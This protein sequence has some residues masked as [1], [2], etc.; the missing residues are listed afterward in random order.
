MPSNLPNTDVHPAPIFSDVVAVAHASSAITVI[1]MRSAWLARQYRLGDLAHI[2]AWGN[3]VE[4]IK[5][6]AAGQRD[7][8]RGMT[9]GEVWVRRLEEE[10]R[11]GSQMLPWLLDGEISS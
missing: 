6:V 3:L 5:V 2:R 1:K 8:L 11:L 10:N 4:R 9:S 7:R